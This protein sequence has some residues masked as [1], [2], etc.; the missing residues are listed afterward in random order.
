MLNDFLTTN[1][2]Y[3]SLKMIYNCIYTKYTVFNDCLCNV[4]KSGNH[5]YD[6]LVNTCCIATGTLTEDERQLTAGREESSV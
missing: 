3:N 6:S 4:G 5:V 2:T 1:R